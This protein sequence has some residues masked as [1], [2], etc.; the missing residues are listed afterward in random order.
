[1]PERKRLSAIYERSA[2]RAAHA[3]RRKMKRRA[4][5]RATQERVAAHAA[6]QRRGI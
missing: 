2:A 4:F 3:A 5:R 1:V 6:M